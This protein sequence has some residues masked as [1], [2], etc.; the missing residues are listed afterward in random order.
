MQIHLLFTHVFHD[1]QF[2]WVQKSSC[3][4][5]PKLTANSAKHVSIRWVN[6][7]KRVWLTTPLETPLLTTSPIIW[8]V[9]EANS[10]QFAGNPV[11]IL[12]HG[13]N[14]IAERHESDPLQTWRFVD[15]TM[16]VHCR[17]LMVWHPC[18]NACYLLFINICTNDGDDMH[19]MRSSRTL[20]P[21]RKTLSLWVYAEAKWTFEVGILRCVCANRERDSW[22]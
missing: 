3:R 21:H 4:L 9:H 15:C 1:L 10:G 6:I 17:C 5:S 12:C 11:Y 8:H 22:C 20:S 7:S 14:I 16:Y 19:Y 2:V 18:K 13:F